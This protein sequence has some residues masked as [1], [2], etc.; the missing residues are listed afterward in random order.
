MDDEVVGLSS[1]RSNLIVFCKKSINRES[2]GFNQL[3]QGALTH[4]NISTEV[5][6][7]NAKSIIQTEIGVFFAGTNGFYYTDGYQIIKLSLELDATYEALTRGEKQRRAVY[8]SYDEITR[9][10][11]WSLRENEGDSEN[12]VFFIFHLNFGVKPSGVFTKASNK[13]LIYPSSVVYFEGEQYFGHKNGFV[14][15]ASKW[16][17]TDPIVDVATSPADWEREAIPY[18]YLSCA[19]SAGTLF[20]RKYITKIHILGNNYRDWET[21]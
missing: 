10:V 12:S 18:E 11:W 14:F 19:M 2:G 4:D 3:G 21:S 16:T 1:T 15:K 6:G 9:R 5:G 8:G 7:L 13:N 17:K 20:E